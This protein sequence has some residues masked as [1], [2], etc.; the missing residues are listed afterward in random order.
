M[1]WKLFFYIMNPAAAIS[2]FSG[3]MM[4][5]LTGTGY[6]SSGWMHIKLTLVL[7][8]LGFHGYCWVLVHRFWEEKNERSGTFFRIF[9]EI[10]TL[11]LIVIVYLVV[12][13]PG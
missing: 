10:P 12:V 9:N 7:L 4:I 13:K 1:E 8:L 6:L 11:L 2:L 5:Y 3:S